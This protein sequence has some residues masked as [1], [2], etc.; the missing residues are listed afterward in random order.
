M[1]CGK[2]TER[3]TSSLHHSVRPERGRGKG[4]KTRKEKD[5]KDESSVKISAKGWKKKDSTRPLKLIRTKSELG[6]EEKGKEGE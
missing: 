5:K 4:R 6:N 2:H 3:E 1:D